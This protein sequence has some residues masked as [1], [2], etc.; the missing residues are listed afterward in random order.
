MAQRRVVTSLAVVLAFACAANAVLAQTQA[1]TTNGTQ[2][3]GDQ[4]QSAAA[5]AQEAANPF[6][7]RWLMQIQQNNNWMDM[8]LVLTGV[9]GTIDS[10]E[11][12]IPDVFGVAAVDHG[13]RHFCHSALRRPVVE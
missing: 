10:Y 2:A 13:A 9:A 12:G 1:T 8:P 7:S 4:G 6:S 11:F 3:S 5:M